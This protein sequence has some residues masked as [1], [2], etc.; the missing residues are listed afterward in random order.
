MLAHRYSSSEL[1]GALYI[2]K[3][4]TYDTITYDTIVGFNMDSKTA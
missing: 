2:L 1:I 4:V 3:Q